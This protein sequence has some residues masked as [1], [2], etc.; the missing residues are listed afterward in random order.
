MVKDLSVSLSGVNLDN[1]ISPA[2]GTFGFG[3]EFADF[4]DINCLG[5]ISLK[6]TTKDERYGN[7]DCLQET[8][9]QYNISNISKVDKIIG[10]RNGF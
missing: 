5:S 2:S 3:Y 7:Y 9:Y 8:P 6:G 10:K 1:P 4:Y